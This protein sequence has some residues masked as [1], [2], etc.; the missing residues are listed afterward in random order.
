M[1]KGITAF[2]MT[3]VLSGGLA[4]ASPPQGRTSYSGCNGRMATGKLQL[5]VTTQFDATGVIEI[6]GVDTRRPTTPFTWIW[7]DG[8]VSQGWFPQYHSYPD[9]RSDYTVKVISHE[10]D[11]T[12]DCAQI[13]VHFALTH[14]G[15]GPVAIQNQGSV[16]LGFANGTGPR[17][18][19]AELRQNCSTDFRRVFVPLPTGNRFTDLCGHE[20][21]ACERVC[22][23]E[24][25]SFS[26]NA[27]SRGGQRDSSRIALC[28]PR[29]AS[30]T[31]E[32]ASIGIKD[33]RVGIQP[34]GILFDGENIWV[35]NN[36]S[37][38]VTKLRASDGADL[39][40]F[41]VGSYPVGIA[42][43]G[44]NIWVANYGFDG[45]G[46]S[47]TKLRASDGAFLGE[48]RVG[49]GPRG[50]A[51]DGK[52]IWTANNG[53]NGNGNTVTEIRSLDG[54]VLGTYVVG[55]GPEGIAFDGAN[56]WVA[57]NGS[58]SVTKLRARDGAVLGTFS[59]GARPFGIT[60]DG[61]NIWVANSG[62][63]VAELS[64]NGH[65]LRTVALGNGAS[66][67]V[68]DGTNLWV[69]SQNS[70]TVTKLRP[71]DGQ[72]LATIPLPGNPWGIT[73]DGT[74]IWASNFTGGNVWEF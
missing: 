58:G 18:R 56:I 71:S 65:V 46:N 5:Q 7:G 20:G 51:F 52:N 37:N 61:E 9:N 12:T 4:D 49:N 43:D 26:C 14:S 13:V 33:F 24:G 11:Q 70:H 31:S 2:F 36:S 23:W 45:S 60:F 53:L 32:P 25:H 59:A 6:N 54:A 38:S 47:V 48:F 17:D 62:S 66:G 68:F 63:S 30:S 15:Q 42:F 69:T 10:N 74:H 34:T 50:V 44:Y 27:V 73:F 40:T 28:K 64:S 3:V 29:I 19:E 39:G 22:D 67:L 21:M 72:I 41:R 16:W 57:N 35:S 8:K 1:I 55:T